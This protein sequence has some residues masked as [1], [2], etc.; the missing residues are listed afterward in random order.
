MEEYFRSKSLKSANYAD[1]KEKADALGRKNLFK[2]VVL[3]IYRK[4]F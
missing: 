4:K 3:I 2:N 1:R